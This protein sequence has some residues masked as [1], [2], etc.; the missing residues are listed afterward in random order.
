MKDIAHKVSGPAWQ[1]N[2]TPDIE[3]TLESS[4]K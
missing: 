4:Y 1:A 3:S 2:F